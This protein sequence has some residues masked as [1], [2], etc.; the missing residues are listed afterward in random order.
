M[1]KN[2]QRGINA[3][4]KLRNSYRAQV[5]RHQNTAKRARDSQSKLQ[6]QIQALEDGAE[7]AD[8]E[9]FKGILEKLASAKLSDLGNV[10]KTAE[11]HEALLK[12]RQKRLDEVKA[13]LGEAA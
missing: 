10:K 6:L 4:K 9:E 12:D 3:L 13:Q 7:K 2:A 1:S 8:N 11:K 5:G